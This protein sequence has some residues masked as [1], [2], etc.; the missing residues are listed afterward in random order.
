MTIG[1]VFFSFVGRLNRHES[2]VI[3]IK[4]PV[5][6]VGNKTSILHILYALFPLNYGRFIDVFGGSGSAY[7]RFCRQYIAPRSGSQGKI[8]LRSSFEDRKDGYTW[9][10]EIPVVYRNNF[11]GLDLT[12]ND[13]D[14]ERLKSKLSWSGRSDSFRNR[15]NFIILELNRGDAA[16]ISAAIRDPGGRILQLVN[17]ESIPFLPTAEWVRH[18]FRF[19]PKH[20]GA[21]NL[22]LRSSLGTDRAKDLRFRNISVQGAEGTLPAPD[23]VMDQAW[24]ALQFRKDVPVTISC[25]LKKDGVQK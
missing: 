13:S 3:P 24:I 22:V 9:T 6:R 10:F 2:E 12:V 7:N 18:E 14:G 17:N 5:S 1:T 21:G 23:K 19:I 11:I 4:T 16:V 25:E 15:R 8:G 20:D